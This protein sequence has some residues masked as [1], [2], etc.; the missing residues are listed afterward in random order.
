MSLDNLTYSYHIVHYDKTEMWRV[1]A[2][3]TVS[4]IVNERTFKTEEE[5]KKFI[6]EQSNG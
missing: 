3:N 2:M 4:K 6:K 5:C 1:V